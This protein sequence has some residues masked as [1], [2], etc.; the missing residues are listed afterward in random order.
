MFHE[1]LIHSVQFFLLGKW[2]FPVESCSHLTHSHLTAGLQATFVVQRMMG[3]S[4]VLKQRILNQQG[5]IMFSFCVHLCSYVIPISMLI[6]HCW[7]KKKKKK[8]ECL[9]T[10]IIYYLGQDAS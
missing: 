4:Q 1:T 7:G 6:G 10:S 3:Y 8:V 5:K 2:R 9:N